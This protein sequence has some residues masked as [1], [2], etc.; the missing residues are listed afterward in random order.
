MMVH[1]KDNV[2]PHWVDHY[3]CIYVCLLKF[4]NLLVKACLLFSTCSYTYILLLLFLTIIES[5][6]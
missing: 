2:L 4:R 5:I 3:L 6:I 1:C